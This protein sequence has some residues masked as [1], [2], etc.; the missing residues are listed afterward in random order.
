QAPG[1]RSGLPAN[2][3]RVRGAKGRRLNRWRSERC[4]RSFAH[5]CVTGGGRRMWLRGVINANK[6]YLLRCCAYNLGLV[7]RKCF[8]LAK[9]RSGGAAAGMLLLSWEFLMAV[10]T[11][12]THRAV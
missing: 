12:S 1:I 4:E 10:S 6:S 7:M 8:G 9:P 5:V 11:E 2:R 3:C